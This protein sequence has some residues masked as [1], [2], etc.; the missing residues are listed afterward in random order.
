MFGDLPTLFGQIINAIWAFLTANTAIEE[1][2]DYISQLQIAGQPIS[3][4]IECAGAFINL[5]VPIK[6][7]GIMLAIKLPVLFLALILS[8]VYRAKSFIPT[9][10]A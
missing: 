10:G 7:I 8:L 5:I 6:A 3:G 2:T 4:F 9:M 1:F